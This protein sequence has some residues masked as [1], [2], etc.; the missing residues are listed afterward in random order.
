MVRGTSYS[1]V[2]AAGTRLLSGSASLRTLNC[3]RPPELAEVALRQ[4][5]KEL[6]TECMESRD[7]LIKKNSYFFTLIL[8]KNPPR[9]NRGI[10]SDNNYYLTRSGKWLL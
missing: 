3:L 10:R 4:S 1:L 2:G 6:S 7:I 9:I 8:I 5:L